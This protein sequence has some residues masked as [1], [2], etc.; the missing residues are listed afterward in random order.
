MKVT[1]SAVAGIV[2][3]L[4]GAL[5]VASASAPDRNP[6]G[7]RRGALRTGGPSATVG[8]RLL[9]AGM[10][11]R[12]REVLSTEVIARP[13]PVVATDKRRHL[14]Y[15]LLLANRTRT[16]VRLDRLEVRN[17]SSGAP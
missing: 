15:E 10:R 14:V 6:G 16:R 5:S 11:A 13:A 4:L 17:P 8:G 2:L 12:G 7:Q 1:S 9:A 3:A